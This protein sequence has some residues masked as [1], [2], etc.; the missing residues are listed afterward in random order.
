MT[1]LA[2]R[3]DAAWCLA[4]TDLQANV[5]VVATTAANAVAL[6]ATTVLLLGAVLLARQWP[7]FRH[8]FRLHA[9]L[10]CDI[11]PAFGLLHI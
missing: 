9:A 2:A 11:R 1:Q 6:V 8:I 7:R 4:M 10:R 3:V 5:L